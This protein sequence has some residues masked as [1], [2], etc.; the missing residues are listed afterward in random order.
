MSSVAPLLP[1]A[2]VLDLFAGSG[3]LGIEALSRGATHA[4][5]VENASAALRVLQQNLDALRVPSERVQIVRSDAI[6]FAQG[7]APHTFHVAFADPPYETQDATRLA[8]LFRVRPF[9]GLLCI[10]HSRAQPIPAAS[11]LRERRY[12]DTLLSFLSAQDDG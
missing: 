11:D 2:G 10:E 5:F 8:Q 9:A 1:G 4:T 3:A 7:L 12:G 6:R